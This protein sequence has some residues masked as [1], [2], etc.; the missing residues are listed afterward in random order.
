MMVVQVYVT[1]MAVVFTV[2]QRSSSGGGLNLTPEKGS[3][4][5]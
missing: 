2:G 1:D 5:L 3:G 4:G